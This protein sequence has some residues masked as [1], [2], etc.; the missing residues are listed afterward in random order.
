M[1]SMID[2]NREVDEKLTSA[3]ETVDSLIDSKKK[4]QCR[5]TT[6]PVNTHFLTCV[7]VAF[8]DVLESFRYNAIVMQAMIVL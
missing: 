3:M 1:G 7:D 2:V 5:P 8:K 4:N 6:N